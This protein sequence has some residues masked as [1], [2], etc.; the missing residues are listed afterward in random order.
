MEFEDILGNISKEKFRL[1]ANK[2]LNA[3]FIIKRSKDTI[4][5]YNFILNNREIFSS[6]FDLLGY[7]LIIQEEYGVIGL[8][9]FTGNGRIHLK[10]IES[11]IL[12]IIRLLYIEKRKQL[13]QTDD[14]IIIADEIYDKYN[15]L[16]LANKLDKTTMRNC[17]GLFRRYNLVQN[18]DF[19]VANPDTRIIIYP[20]ILFAITPKSLDEVYEATK[21]KIDKYISGGESD[22]GTENEETDEN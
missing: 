22:N 1:S 7:E 4:S 13:S 5:D 14:V 16:K 15:M 21:D 18:L 10:K 8:N 17:I 6:Y 19:D 9:S 12:L 2:L 20:S 3:C 11:F